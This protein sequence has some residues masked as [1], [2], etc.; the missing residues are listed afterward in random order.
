MDKETIAAE[1]LHAFEGAQAAVILG[2]GLGVMERDIAIS[3]SIPYSEI[4]GFPQ[5]TVTSHSG[6]L[7]KGTLGGKE[8]W[9]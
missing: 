8:S 5:S 2:T 9:S 1:S 7:L 6:R 3:A 4:P